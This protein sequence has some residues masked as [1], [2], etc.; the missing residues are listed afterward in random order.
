MADEQTTTEQPQNSAEPPDYLKRIREYMGQVNGSD[1]YVLTPD[2]LELIASY[3]ALRNMEGQVG[4]IDLAGRKL[5]LTGRQLDLSGR[6]LDLAGKEQD[7]KQGPYFDWYSGPYFEQMKQQAAN[8][9]LMSQNDLKRTANSLA[10]SR[11]QT[12]QA[13]YGAQMAR[14]QLWQSLGVIPPSAA[15]REQQRQQKLKA[16]QSGTTAARRPN[17]YGYAGD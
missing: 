4:E 12:K 3:Y 11:Y 2:D 6:E 15:Q 1:G 14:D 7:F 13:E 10:S 9:L 17:S 8:D 16:I 5:D